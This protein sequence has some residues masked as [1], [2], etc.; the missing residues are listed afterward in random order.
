[1]SV[2]PCAILHT[3]FPDDMVEEDGEIVEFGGRL[4]TDAI[5]SVLR[6]LGYEVSAL[7]FAGMSIVSIVVSW[8]NTRRQT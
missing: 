8:L 1:M 6:R 7:P 4:I 2:R 3:N 5:I